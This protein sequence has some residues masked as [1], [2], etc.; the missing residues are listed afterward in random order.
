MGRL[1]GGVGVRS[2]RASC[3][4]ELMG[5]GASS[6]AAAG[7]RGLAG[8]HRAVPAGQ[9]DAQMDREFSVRGFLCAAGSLNL[10]WRCHPALSRFEAKLEPERPRCQRLRRGV[11][12]TKIRTASALPPESARVTVTEAMVRADPSRFQ[13]A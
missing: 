1:R 4:L 8:P 7:L 13:L 9:D 5:G 12:Q 10:M 2:R 11:A 6:A 3:S